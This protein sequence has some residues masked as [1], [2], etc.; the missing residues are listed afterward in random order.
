MVTKLFGVCHNER[1]AE[2]IIQNLKLRKGQTVGLEVPLRTIKVFEKAHENNYIKEQLENTF[3]REWYGLVA[4]A[5]QTNL[6][7]P[8]EKAVSRNKKGKEEILFVFKEGTVISVKPTSI[9]N[10]VDGTMFFYKIF[11]HAKKR[12]CKC[13]SLDSK[14]A[15]NALSAV[16]F[17]DRASNVKTRKTDL[18]ELLAAPKLSKADAILPDGELG[19]KLS[20]KQ[21]RE[22]NIVFEILEKPVR[23][24]GMVKNIIGHNPDVA[25]VGLGHVNAIHR[26]LSIEEHPNKIVYKEKRVGIREWVK[27]NE[28]MLRAE[29]TRAYY[30]KTQSD[31]KKARREKIIRKKKI[32]T[33]R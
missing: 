28:I 23:E 29:I 15:A 1:F 14:A 2:K 6:K 5:L 27:H 3:L 30:R 22:Q 26:Q 21:K 20:L 24:K 13:V 7:Q 4:Q 19:K 11:E 16:S 17:R 18:T 25:I 8:F 31:K 33:P 12:G 9:R 32:R 10:Y